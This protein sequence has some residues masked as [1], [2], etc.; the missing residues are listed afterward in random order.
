VSIVPV[1]LAA[2]ESKRMGRAKALLD[3]DGRSAIQLA[4]DACRSMRPIVVLGRDHA[5][6]R[7][8]VRDAVVV[9]NLDP[10]SGRTSSLKA[11]LRVLPADAEAF[12]IHPVDCPL[13]TAALV[14]AVVDGWRATGKAIVIP[15]NA[16]KRGHPALF[17]AALKG[18]FL[19]LGDDESAR[20]VAGADPARVHH[21]DAPEECLF[22]MD[23]PEDYARCLAR[24][25]E[26]TRRSG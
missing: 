15:S 21:V 26:I 17:A 10:A 6:I 23:T 1:I 2:G 16:M 8:S 4:L 24:Y 9:V 19:A 25:R 3:F 20:K 7:G 11:G 18:E 22:D 5:A 13:I 14:A 12:L